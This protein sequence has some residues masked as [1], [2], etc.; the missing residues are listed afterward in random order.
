MA[1][2]TTGCI[3]CGVELDN[4]D[5]NDDANQPYDGVMVSTRGNY[6]S[7]VF[8]PENGEFLLFIVCDECL[9]KAGEQGRVL[10]GQR[11]RPLLVSDDRFPR[12]SR[13]GSI[14]DIDR[15][16]VPWYR[17][18]PTNDERLVIDV[19]SLGEYLDDD[20]VTWHGGMGKI[21]RELAAA[22]PENP[23]KEG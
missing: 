23:P 11:E 6:G 4:V 16:L 17:A 22:G 21:A 19:E 14:R 1:K 20:R 2:T 10:L 5:P 13:W 18:I 15:Q 9:V 8:D 3:V 12:G 7:T